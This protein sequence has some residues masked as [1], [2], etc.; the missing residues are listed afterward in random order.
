MYTV[1][2]VQSV[3]ML[4]S[5][6]GLVEKKIMYLNLLCVNNHQYIYCAG[7]SLHHFG[8]VFLTCFFLIQ[9]AFLMIY[10][11]LKEFKRFVLV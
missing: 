10:D 5:F 7:S 1:Y 8:I 2:V 9:D 4:F 11:I 6:F 3:Y